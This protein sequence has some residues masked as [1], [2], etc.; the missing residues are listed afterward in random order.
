MRIMPMI[1]PVMSVR[2]FPTAMTVDLVFHKRNRLNNVGNNNAC[3]GF[4]VTDVLNV[5]SS[6]IG[7]TTNVPGFISYA[8]LYR[9]MRTVSAQIVVDFMNREA[10]QE[11]VSLTPVNK[12][13][14]TN[15][16]AFDVY[17]DQPNTIH[18][19]T[20]TITGNS[21]RRLRGMWSTAV[22][23][24]APETD[25]PDTYT[26]NTDYGAGTHRPDNNW[27]ILVG[28]SADDPMTALG[29]V[30]VDITITMK[31]RF[32]EMNSPTT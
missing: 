28:A 21:T 14:A 11:T 30:T 19:S 17:Y 13:V 3:F 27:Y 29:G 5:D 26:G 24:G 9:Q 25:V 23:G 8:N 18:A 12:V 7:T 10:F 4:Q 2:G 15:D 31:V 1:R 32:F 6:Q 22:F 20:G 16:P